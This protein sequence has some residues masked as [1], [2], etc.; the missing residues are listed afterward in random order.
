MEDAIDIRDFDTLLFDT[1]LYRCLLRVLAEI[2]SDCLGT[3]HRLDGIPYALCAHTAG[4]YPEEREVIRTALRLVIDLHSA[5][6]CL[7]YT[8]D[9]ADE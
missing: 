1:S 4:F 3:G 5:D 7:L 8:S 6:L 9:A 2:D